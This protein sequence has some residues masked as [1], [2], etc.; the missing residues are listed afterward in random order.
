MSTLILK[1][2]VYP[3]DLDGLHP[4]YYRIHKRSPRPFNCG[5]EI[6]F[7][8]PD[9]FPA[10]R[11][12]KCRRWGMITDK[13]KLCDFTYEQA[14]E[15]I[16]GMLPVIAAESGLYIDEDAFAEFFKSIQEFIKE[17]VA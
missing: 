7:G 17:N 13:I 1:K 14:R 4:E 15:L 12:Y 11:F 2:I 6:A 5:N 3:G 8:I 10:F 9:G 16:C